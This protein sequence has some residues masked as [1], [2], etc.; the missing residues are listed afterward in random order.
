MCGRYTV[1]ADPEQLAERF[2]AVLPPGLLQPRYN[3]APTQQLP[4]L[5]NEDERQIQLLRWGLVPHWAKTP[6][7]DYSMI[8]ARAETV[9]QK[10]TFRE[11]LHKRRCLVLADSFYEWQKTATGK[12]PMRIMLKSGEPFA[13]AGL[14]EAWQDRATG[15]VL[16][17][18]TIITTNANELISP[19]HN[20][21]PVIFL[22]KD[23][24]AWLDNQAAPDAWLGLLHP[25]AADLMKTYPVSARVNS[26]ANDDPSLVALAASGSA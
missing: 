6:S 4:V 22:P 17:S 10:P 8:N 14:W 18:F 5:L 2:S 7:T 9:E 26:P 3:A 1:S 23:E 16:R 24:N 21:M 15:E 11:A 19:I 13:F 20:R 12:I 25:Y